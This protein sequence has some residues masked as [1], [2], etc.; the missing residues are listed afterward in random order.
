MLLDDDAVEELSERFDIDIDPELVA[1][2]NHRVAMADHA[3]DASLVTNDVEGILARLHHMP[4]TARYAELRKLEREVKA[5]HI[6]AELIA[7]SVARSFEDDGLPEVRMWQLEAARRISSVHTQDL[8]FWHDGERSSMPVWNHHAE[9]A[10]P[11]D[12]M[13]PIDSPLAPI[14]RRIN[15]LVDEAAFHALDQVGRPGV[16]H[17]V[18]VFDTALPRAARKL[19]A[20]D[21]QQAEDL[22][23]RFRAAAQHPKFS[24]W[25]TERATC[26]G[27]PVLSLD[28]YL[29]GTWSA[30]MTLSYREDRLA[31]A[32]RLIS[33]WEDSEHAQEPSPAASPAMALDIG[34]EPNDVRDEDGHS[35]ALVLARLSWTAYV[36]PVAGWLA[37][38][39]VAGGLAALLF[40]ATV[41]VLVA[42][43]CTAIALYRALLLRSVILFLDDEGVWVQRGLLPW[44]TGVHGVKWRDLDEAVFVPGFLDWLLRSH[45]IVLRHRFTKTAEIGLAHVARGDQVVTTINAWHARALGER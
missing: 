9:L 7:A 19:E 12:T 29:N 24:A 5:F 30:R 17:C 39:V 21:A 1:E 35:E 4:R 26:N 2:F 40:G 11:A 34:H 25:F 31:G 44:D 36:G 23:R 18:R 38:L 3:V 10:I 22:T 42:T 43:T 28:E 14:E 15:A 27:L 20:R 13:H 45:T 6:Y 32:D 41:G 8:T 33:N 37:V 16:A